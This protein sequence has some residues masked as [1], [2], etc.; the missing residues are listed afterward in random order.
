MDGRQ[1]GLE[2]TFFE[3]ESIFSADAAA[4]TLIHGTNVVIATIQLWFF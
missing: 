3:R 1:Q 4:L 2:L